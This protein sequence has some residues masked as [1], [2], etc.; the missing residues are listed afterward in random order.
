MEPSASNNP[1]P[2]ISPA[3]T[4]PPA[5]P[6]PGRSLAVVEPTHQFDRMIDLIGDLARRAE[7]RSGQ[8]TMLSQSAWSSVAK[9]AGTF[10]LGAAL[11]FGVSHEVQMT[12]AH[13][14]QQSTSV[15]EQRVQKVSLAQINSDFSRFSQKLSDPNAGPDSYVTLLGDIGKDV[16]AVLKL[17]CAQP[18][19]EEGID[20]SNMLQIEAA[21]KVASQES[22][23]SVER[24]VQRFVDLVRSLC[25]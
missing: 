21:R 4:E 11:M 6:E 9:Y 17:P 12:P 22:V 14:I 20:L 15:S 25:N 24:R 1:E 23:T 8:Q 7:G 19:V 10:V 16:K 3:Q 18:A 5:P 2:S 13:Q